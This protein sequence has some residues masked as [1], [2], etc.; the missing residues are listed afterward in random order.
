MRKTLTGVL[1]GTVLLMLL[2]LGCAGLLLGTEAGLQFAWPHLVRLAGPALSVESVS[3]RLSGPL[4]LQ[5]VG[6]RTDRDLVRAGELRL[7]W[8]PLALAGGVICGDAGYQ[9]RLE[10]GLRA[11]NPAPGVVTRVPEPVLGCLRIGY[12]HLDSAD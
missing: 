2:L 8:D 10:A 7:D 11:I 6:Y 9:A 12:A 4:H 1:I 3:G 5:G